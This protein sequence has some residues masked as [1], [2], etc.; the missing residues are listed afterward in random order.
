[1]LNL[2]AAKLP[3]LVRKRDLFYFIKFCREHPERTG[4]RLA[5]LRKSGFS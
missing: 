3:P 2:A 1:M 5:I 4:R